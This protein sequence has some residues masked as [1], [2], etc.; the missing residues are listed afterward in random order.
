[1]ELGVDPALESGRA[2]RRRV[3]ARWR[4]GYRIDLDLRD[5]R[6]TLVSDEPPEDGGTDSGPMPSE[7]LFAGVASCFAMAVAWAARKRRRELVD[8]EVSVGGAY[9]RPGRRYSRL[10]VAASSSLAR[11]DPGEFAAI[12]RLAEEVCWVTRTIGPGVLVEV[13]G[14]APEP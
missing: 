12:L 13:R 14:G 3:R 10:E 1:M 9:D 6:F 4:D 2:V 7:L 11:T 8:L 5:G